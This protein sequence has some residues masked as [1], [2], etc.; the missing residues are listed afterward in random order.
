MSATQKREFCVV[1]LTARPGTP[2]S[3]YCRQCSDKVGAAQIAATKLLRKA[4]RNGMPKAKA[5][6]C[7]DCFAPAFDYDHRD[8]SKPLEVVPV[9]RRCNQLRGPADR[10]EVRSA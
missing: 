2:R 3:P 9:C 5:L 7:V 6:Q 8:Y 1:C 4:I 10:H